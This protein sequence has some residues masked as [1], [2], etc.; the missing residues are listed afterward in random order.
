M[1]DIQGAIFMGHALFE[2]EFNRQTQERRCME[3]RNWM[4]P[5][6]N[7]PH[8]KYNNIY[9]I[10]YLS[11]WISSWRDM[12]TSG[13]FW[14]DIRYWSKERWWIFLQQG[15]CWALCFPLLKRYYLF[16][17]NVMNIS[18]YEF[19]YALR[20]RVMH[21]CDFTG[22]VTAKQWVPSKSHEVH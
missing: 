1:L 22:M 3:H 12:I 13:W 11:S 6:S 10:S 2:G 5:C 16:Q 4:R 7:N 9:T 15:W 14:G 19:V 21:V 20:H 8:P 17:K 18:W